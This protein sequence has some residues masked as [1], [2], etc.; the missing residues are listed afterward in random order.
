MPPHPSPAPLRLPPS[1][2]AIPEASAGSSG[3]ALSTAGGPA[4]GGRAPAATAAAAAAA[5]AAAMSAAAAAAG[6]EDGDLLVVRGLALM[7]RNEDLEALYVSD[8]SHSLAAAGAFRAVSTRIS[9]LLLLAA[10]AA[11][12]LSQRLLVFFVAAAT[13]QIVW[14]ALRPLVTAPW[15]AA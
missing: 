12:Y 11:F 5:S 6:D 7:F 15:P 13:I 1:R 9:V 8:S 14:A 4:G 2:R 3:V 10:V